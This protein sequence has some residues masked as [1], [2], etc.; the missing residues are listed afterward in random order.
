MSVTQI[1]DPLKLRTSYGELWVRH[2]ADYAKGR[3]QYEKPLAEG[4]AVTCSD[5][6]V[7]P[8]LVRVQSSC[9]FGEAFHSTECD[10]ASQLHAA[11]ERIVKN[12]GLL[13]YSYEEGRGAGLGNKVKAMLL[14]QKQ[15]LRTDEAYRK[16]NLPADLRSYELAGYVIKSLL[17]EAPA[18]RLMT[19][20]PD[21]IEKLSQQG[22]D[23]QEVEKIIPES[24][25]IDAASEMIAK[26]EIFHHHIPRSALNGHF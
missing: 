15:R 23:I 12:N 2:F 25:N 17:G 6:P 19:N 3:D 11:I 24:I 18:I 1:S 10:C 16:L 26:Y 20:N 5:K 13:V 21:K 7:A 9:V 22:I 4:I 14:Q 8:T